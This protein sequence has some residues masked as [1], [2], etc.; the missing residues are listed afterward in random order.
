MMKNIKKAMVIAV[1]F[2]AV[3]LIGVGSTTNKADAKKKFNALTT[4]RSAILNTKESKKYCKAGKIKFVYDTEKNRFKLTSFKKNKYAPVSKKTFLKN[5]DTTG[6]FWIDGKKYWSGMG[7]NY[8]KDV[9][10]YDC[11]ETYLANGGNLSFWSSLPGLTKALTPGKHKVKVEFDFKGNKNGRYAKNFFWVGTINIKEAYNITSNKPKISHVEYREDDLGST[12][13]HK[14]SVFSI[15]NILTNVNCKLN[16]NVKYVFDKNHIKNRKQFDQSVKRSELTEDDLINYI[17]SQIGNEVNFST[18]MDTFKWNNNKVWNNP[19]SIDISKYP[20][21]NNLTEKANSTVRF[22]IH[23]E[24][25][26][27][28]FAPEVTCTF[29]SKVTGKVLGTETAVVK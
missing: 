6:T 19:Y 18:N 17:K 25:F 21:Y 27:S 3:T 28:M 4:K 1:A 11:A 10:G 15:S 14:K 12:P 5:L 20:N 9:K 13:H 8:Y 26:W 29:T 22:C 2:A 16:I 7:D 23:P 24:A